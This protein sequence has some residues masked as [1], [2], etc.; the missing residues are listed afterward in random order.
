MSVM[1]MY[2]YQKHFSA[3]EP[4]NSFA[5]K[6]DIVQKIKEQPLLDRT[7]T[8]RPG[9]LS[10]KT[11]FGKF[12][13]VVFGINAEARDTIMKRSGLRLV[14]GRFPEENAP[15]VA[16]ST[17]IARNRNFKLGDIVLKPDSEDS[18]AIV[19]VK[20]VGLIEGPVWFAVTSESFIQN[21]F[22]LAKQDYLVLAHS[23]KE[24]RELDKILTDTLD[25]GRTRLWTYANLVRD[26]NDALRNLYLIMSIVI[27]IIVFSIAFLVGMLASIYFTQRLP[28]FATLTA[29]GYQRSGLLLRVLGET[30]LMCVVGWA[31]GSLLT[32]GV[33]CAIKAWIMNP[34]GLLIDPFDWTAYRFTIPLPLA[35]AVFATYAIARRL[36]SLDPVGIIERRQ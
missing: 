29:I 32:I 12:L 28:E 26:T 6:S 9:F 2:G 14:E 5:L 25:K 21:N 11:T 30:A 33:L 23:E 15:E 1:T 3:V 20:L 27:A 7:F 22:P 8:G 31:I 24:Q 10:V 19:P 13:F 35:I 4:R 16:L 36:R 18:Y 17:D 34:R